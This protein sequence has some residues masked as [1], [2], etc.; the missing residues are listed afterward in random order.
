MQILSKIVESN[1]SMASLGNEK[2]AQ[3]AKQAVV[4]AK[5]QNNNNHIEKRKSLDSNFE[6]SP[7]P[8]LK[9]Q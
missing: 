9:K 5:L 7:A 2:A 1:R 4:A 8:Q 6:V 3:A